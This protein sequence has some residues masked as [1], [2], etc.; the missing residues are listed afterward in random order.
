MDENVVLGSVADSQA[1]GGVLWEMVFKFFSSAGSP[2]SSRSFLRSSL[3]ATRS[4]LT[5][6]MVASVDRV[7]KHYMNEDVL[8]LDIWTLPKIKHGIASLRAV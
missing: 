6:A 5:L 2:E 8:S 1:A 3:K 4:L 7:L